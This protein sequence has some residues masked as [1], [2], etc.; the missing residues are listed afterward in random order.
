MRGGMAPPLKFAVVREDP[1]LELELV[2]RFSCKRPLVVA[3]GGCTA[4]ALM[5]E[6]VE[7]VTAF[8]FNPTQ[9]AH[10]ETKR[11]ARARGDLEA[12]GV[13]STSGLHE[14]GAFE[15]LFRVL[16]RF[17]DEFVNPIAFDN[18][19]WPA[20]F[21]TTFNDAFLHAMFGPA[22]TQHAERGSYPGYFQR[23]FQ[24]G[25]TRGGPNPFLDHVFRGSYRREALPLY[26]TAEERAPLKLVEGTLLDVPHLESFDL[27]SLSNVFDWS[28]DILVAEWAAALTKAPPG[29]VVL[30]RQLNN[31]R[32]LR[33][34]FAP[35]YRFDDALGEEL[36]ARDQSLFYERIEVGVRQ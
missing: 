32:D 4:L 27:F 31:R 22:A 3:S 16:R 26:I 17:V 15:G 1:S 10:V 23:A 9:L 24:R 8:D 18:P 34:F 21:H 14:I 20:A 11:A 35:H 12:L 6:A 19:Y 33:A 2:R 36:C 5:G 13:E 29:S 25:L 30:L 7:S 28:D